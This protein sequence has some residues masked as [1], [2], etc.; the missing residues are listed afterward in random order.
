MMKGLVRTL[1]KQL[2]Q[3][4]LG[5]E[6]RPDGSALGRG[7]RGREPKDNEPQISEW[8]TAEIAEK[9]LWCE[10]QVSPLHAVLL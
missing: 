5:L 3:G 9:H 2:L 1:L 6:P 8:T 4:L 10:L 7:R